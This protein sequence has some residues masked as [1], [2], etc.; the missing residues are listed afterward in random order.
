[1]ISRSSGSRN[2]L[3]SLVPEGRNSPTST[4]A[5]DPVVTLLYYEGLNEMDSAELFLAAVVGF[6]FYEATPQLFGASHPFVGI[7]DT[8]HDSV[9]GW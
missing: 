8:T 5:H 2:T 6:R 9:V 1:M 3:V 4:L 7:A